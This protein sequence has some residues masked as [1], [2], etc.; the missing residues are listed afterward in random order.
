MAQE[1]QQEDVLFEG[2]LSEALAKA[3]LGQSHFCI[4]Q[5][6]DRLKVDVSNDFD[7]SNLI[8]YLIELSRNNSKFRQ[9]LPNYIIELSKVC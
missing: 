5:D 6:G 4:T 7:F 2:E 3:A 8:S 9:I 1:K